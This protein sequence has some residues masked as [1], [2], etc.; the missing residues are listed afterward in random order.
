[1]IDDEQKERIK[2]EFIQETAKK[3]ES[4][5]HIAIS[6]LLAMFKSAA[7]K[8]N[9]PFDLRSVTLKSYQPIGSVIARE[10]SKDKNITQYFNDEEIITLVNSAVSYTVDSVIDSTKDII[11]NFEKEQND[12]KA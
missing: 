2:I 4:L 10:L 3:I 6:T 5:S 11:E 1:M 7:D 12:S 9:I 8:K